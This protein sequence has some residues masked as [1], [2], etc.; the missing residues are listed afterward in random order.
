MKK[1]LAII[2]LTVVVLLVL[3]MLCV[4][5]YRQNRMLKEQNSQMEALAA[6]NTTAI[7]IGSVINSWFS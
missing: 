7:S 1:T 2:L 4:S 5:T 6:Q 3:G